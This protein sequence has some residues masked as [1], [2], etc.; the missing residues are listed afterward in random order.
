LLTIDRQTLIAV[1]RD[2]IRRFEDDEYPRILERLSQAKPSGETGSSDS[3]TDD[4]PVVADPP[5]EYVLSRS[6]RTVFDKA[7]LADE[8]DVDRYLDKL[9][10]AMMKEIAAGK[11]IQI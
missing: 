9:K 8:A 5:V 3:P 10:E 1:I 11:R 4:K 2:T 7:W 6:I